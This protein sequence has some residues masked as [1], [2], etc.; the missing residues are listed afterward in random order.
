MTRGWSIAAASLSRFVD[1]ERAAA[2]VEFALILPVMLILYL[3]SIEATSLYTIDRRV[4]TISSTMGDLVSQA[5][6]VITQAKINDYFE[7]AE[8]ILIP[9]P[10]ANLRQVVSLIRVRNNGS[11]QVI[12]S[13]TA[14]GTARTAGASYP[15]PADSQMN[16]IARD[17]GY[18]VAAEAYYTYTP[19]FESVIPG[20][21]NL[22]RESFYLPRFGACIELQNTCP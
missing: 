13:R 14:G 21:V 8:G 1:T 7:A 10:T 15:L 9:Y 6:D 12:W 2:A 17:T 4:T 18:L 5:D 20:P 16:R 22:Y 3:G 19:V 11:T